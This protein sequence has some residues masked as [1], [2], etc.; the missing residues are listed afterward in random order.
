MVQTSQAMG[1]R[2]VTGS[3]EAL[4]SVFIDDLRELQGEDPLAC[5]NVL[6]G[7]NVLAA[8]LKKRIAATGRGA[9]NLRFHTFLDLAHRLVNPGSLPEGKPR[10]AGL[11]APLIIE[12]IL[13]AGAPA[14]F[15]GVSGYAG[16]RDALLG[17]FR[18]LR[19]AGLD[20]GTLERSLKSMSSIPPDRKKLLEEVAWIYCRFREKTQA[21]REVDD[22]FRDALGNTPRAAG[23]LDSRFLL[24]YG[25]YDVTGQQADLLSALKDRLEMHY[26]IPFV[27]ESVSAFAARFLD[28]R[29]DE[30]GVAPE[31]VKP[32]QRSTDLSRLWQEDCGFR[33]ATSRRAPPGASAAGDR[34]V[35]M[36]SAPGDSRVALEIAREIVRA[37]ADGTIDGFG[38]AAVILRHPEDDLP[39]IVEAFRLRGIPCYVHGGLP[40]RDR[41]FCRA[42]LAIAELAPG[43]F[44]REA[45][46]GAMELTAASL[47]EADAGL[48]EV[49]EWRS[50]TNDARF[51]AGSDSWDKATSGLVVELGRV[52]METVAGS[53]SLPE[54]SETPRQELSMLQ[55]R[56]ESARQLRAAW[57]ELK[58]AADNWPAAQTWPDWARFLEE[59]LAPLLEASHDWTAFLQVLDQVSSLGEVQ[60]R[61]GNNPEV[62]RERLSRVLAESMRAVRSPAGRFLRSGVNL[63][64]VSAARGLRFPLVLVPDLEEARFP[65]RLRQDPLLL[66]DE[67]S[68]V[69][70]GGRMPLRRLRFD[71]ERLLFDMTARSAERR[72]VL[73]T[74]RLDEGSDRERIPSEFFMRAAAAM[75]RKP[76][77]LR[78]LSE[79]VIPGYRSVSLENPAPNPGLPAVDRAE[80]RMRLVRSAPGRGREVLEK[81]AEAEPELFHRPLAYD[82]ARWQPRLSQYDGLIT[83]R[84]LLGYLRTGFGPGAGPY[85]AG[86]I[87]EYAR[88]PYLFYQRRVMQLAPWEEPEAAEALAPLERGST[89]HG[90]L[91]EF[92]RGL[93]GIGFPRERDRH[94]RG[95][96]LD[97][98]AG[99]L[100]K[101]RP[102]GIADLLWEV[103]R[104]RLLALM[105]EWLRFELDRSD[106][107]LI[108][109]AVELPFGPFERG[110]DSPGLA[111]V[112]GRHRFMLRG[113]IDR[114]DTSADGS[115]A[116]VVDY[117]VGKLPDSMKRGTALL[118]GERI[119]LPVYRAAVPAIAGFEKLG[120]IEG[121]FLHL[122]PGDG[123]IV[124]RR[125]TAAEL[126]EG[127]ERLP[128]VLEIVG[129][130]IEAGVFFARTSGLLHGGWQCNYCDYIRICGKDRQQREER[131]AADPLVL[132]FNRI[133]EIDVAGEDQA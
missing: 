132:R 73:L 93:I 96:M 22:D 59:R 95:L 7:S 133:Q 32:Q 71:E 52:V 94:L 1:H 10:L 66:D 74:S 50:I 89:V 120:S 11:G 49:S 76:V 60:V 5:A 40:F 61:S 57:R 54:D 55:T 8:Y 85:S 3:F 48:Y 107:G 29:A 123:K 119:Q 15:Q 100:E 51:L 36:V 35:C 9:A 53:P 98:A 18:D 45:I 69:G 113:I 122:Q 127:C 44:G 112:A 25:I 41:P 4:E 114:I 62:P 56:L 68:R 81:L 75:A 131:K 21:F 23:M 129:D 105:E 16:F 79:A 128:A 124:A 77:T 17:T 110:K 37:V 116:R 64:S 2:I 101:A 43:D 38:D 14:V 84:Q 34:S 42:V 30:L 87:E 83:D 90:A 104:D 80:I 126:E 91:E 109:S 65:A 31:R 99:A 106:G 20:P 63:L 28:A 33:A 108:P 125:F 121:E 130:G 26:F 97:L 103:E 88:C 118:A 70:S 24:V 117:K 86:R 47:P 6:V 12:S 72:L 78:E 58:H 19:D 13:A 82:Q 27:D 39:A 67:R 115:L 92:V 102:A 46:L 111:I